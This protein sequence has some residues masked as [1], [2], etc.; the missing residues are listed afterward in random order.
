MKKYLTIGEA[1]Q[2]LNLQV[3]TVRRL[4]RSGILKAERTNGKHRRFRTEVIERYAGTRQ[5]APPRTLRKVAAPQNRSPTSDS[6]PSRPRRERITADPFPKADEWESLA[7][8]EPSPPADRRNGVGFLPPSKPPT[9]TFDRSRDDEAK[10]LQTIKALGLQAIP[11]TIP[12][13]WRGRVV[14]ELERFVTRTQFPTYLSL[15]EAGTFVRA[16]V[17]EVLEPYHAELAR[18]T[19]ERAERIAT[20]SRLEALKAHGRT[21]AVR[22]TSEW[23]WSDASEA[24]REVE[25]VLDAEVAGEWS[26]R[27]VEDL[28]DDI[29]DEFEEDEE[30]DEDVERDSDD[31]D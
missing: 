28:A 16:R 4:E 26:E 22:E 2:R 3:D 9:V 13:T 17:E 6:A 21:Y 19:H 10:R 25:R 30:A 7:D 5:V 29:L 20:E 1:A 24:R 11:F 27:D 15:F 8:L 31:E 23:E 18:Q 12:A 14:A